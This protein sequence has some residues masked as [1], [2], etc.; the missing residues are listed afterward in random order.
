MLR[1]F[2]TETG[3]GIAVLDNELVKLE[4]N[5]NDPNILS[6]IFRVVHTIKGTCGFLGL[7]RLEA[8]A[9]AA[10]TVLGNIHDGELTVTEETVTVILESLDCIKGLLAAVEQTGAEPAGDDNALIGRLETVAEGRAAPGESSAAEAIK[11]LVESDGKDDA[12]AVEADRASAI[13]PPP[14]ESETAEPEAA[15]ATAEAARNQVTASARV[16]LGLPERDAEASSMG[17]VV[18][19]DGE[20][21]SFLIDS[22]GE[23]LNVPADRYERNPATLDS[24]WREVSAG[25]YR[26]DD[27]LLVVMDVARMLDFETAEAA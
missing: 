26:L 15:P 5:P 7:P 20:L 27:R 16:R 22:V 1:A 9:H 11:T 2:L 14:D 25:I 19:H 12:E 4:K 10:E 13:T 3:E 21:Y 17:V 8:V 24:R 23:V 6:E 18:E